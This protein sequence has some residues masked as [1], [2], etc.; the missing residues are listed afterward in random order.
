M[1]GLMS[2]WSHVSRTSFSTVGAKTTNRPSCLIMKHGAMDIKAYCPDIWDKLLD[3]TEFD[4]EYL[5]GRY[6][7]ALHLVTGADGALYFWDPEETKTADCYD[8]AIEH[9]HAIQMAW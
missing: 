2:T 1:G 4:E 6:D 5:M 8:D 7:L 9:D 3:K